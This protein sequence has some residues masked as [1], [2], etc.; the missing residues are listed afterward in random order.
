MGER[1]RGGSCLVKRESHV[2]G[3]G[4]ILCDLSVSGRVLVHLRERPLEVSVAQ[5]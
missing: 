1:G 2:P 4:R 5:P 3:V